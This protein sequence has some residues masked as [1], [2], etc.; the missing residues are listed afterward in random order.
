MRGEVKVKM[1]GGCCVGCMGGVEKKIGEKKKVNGGE[2]LMGNGV[3][4]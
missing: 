1:G 2:L 4:E 3:K